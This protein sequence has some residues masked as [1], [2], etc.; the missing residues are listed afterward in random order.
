MSV[1]QLP[2]SLYG[3][4]QPLTAQIFPPIVSKRNPAT[5]DFA[6]IGSVW[7]NI[8]TPAA[9]LLVQISSNIATWI[10][11]ESAGGAGVF[12]SLT[13]TPGPIDLTGVLTQLGTANINAT[14]AAATNIGAAG[15]TTTI[16]GTVNINAAGAG[17]T[18]INT[19]GSGALHIGNA[20][21]NTAVTGSLTAT[22]AIQATGGAVVGVQLIATG[23]LT[24]GFAGETSLTNAS[25]A[26]GGTSVGM[27]VQT[28][29]GAGVTASAG[30]LKGYLGVTPIYIPYWTQ[31]T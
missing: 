16:L 23:D 10:L 26:A 6:P 30:F 12:A 20:T 5:N 18:T 28:S 9:Y 15:S 27:V 29:A 4:P 8:V 19:G 25:V 17:V 31:T 22:L 2:N 24:N 21:G 1:K 7:V 11:I 14:G 3:L 13:V